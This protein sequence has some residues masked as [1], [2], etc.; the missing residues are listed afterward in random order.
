M[1]MFILEKN[2]QN[3]YNG[4]WGSLW[5]DTYISGHL[6][7]LTHSSL[8]TAWLLHWPS[9]SSHNVPIS[10]PS[11]RISPASSLFQ[12]GSFFLVPLLLSDLNLSISSPLNYQSNYLL[13]LI[14]KLT[15]PRNE[16]LLHKTFYNKY[17]YLWSFYSCLSSRAKALSALLTS[18]IPL[19]YKRNSQIIVEVEWL[20][21]SMFISEAKNRGKA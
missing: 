4:L 1:N 21:P 12:E 14:F 3:P 17:I 15:T 2:I 18:P 9:F 16:L 20:N 13:W 19:I 5:P 10:L 8:L 11:L 6:Y 7:L